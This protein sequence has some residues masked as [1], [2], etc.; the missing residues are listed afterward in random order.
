MAKD[1]GWFDYVEVRYTGTGKIDDVDAFNKYIEEE[2]KSKDY[3]FFDT[4]HEN[5]VPGMDQEFMV[6]VMFDDDI[7]LNS[8]IVFG[9]FIGLNANWLR[10]TIGDDF[11][12]HGEKQ[13]LDVIKAVIDMYKF[14]IA[15]TIAEI[16][17]NHI[18]VESIANSIKVDESQRPMQGG[19][20]GKPYLDQTRLNAY[21]N[22]K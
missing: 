9:G 18:S 19:T 12:R 7:N 11:D 15:K 1:Y 16:A 2:F 17:G 20:G 22:K 14:D 5:T 3:K 10:D 8:E 6:G 21:A 13:L 4:I